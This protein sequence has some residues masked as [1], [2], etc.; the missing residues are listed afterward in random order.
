[1]DKGEE[2]LLAV[3]NSAPILGG[4]RTDGLEGADGEELARRFGG[5]GSRVEI[6]SLRSTRDVLQGMIRGN[7]EASSD[8]G[9]MLDRAEFAPEVT[10]SGVTWELRTSS[11]DWL[12]VRFVLA[13][14]RVVAEL[15]GRLRACANADC[16]LFL[17]DH[18]RAGT[19]RWCSMA[20]CGNRAKA[21]GHAQRRKQQ[22]EGRPA[23]GSGETYG[24]R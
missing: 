23:N 18:S 21:R 9:R 24:G 15:P 10:S 3:L 8:I 2:L 4:S 19:A 13:W 12:A 14:A 16:N 20:T 6:A 7:A 5:S 1:M 17:V 22:A 11:D